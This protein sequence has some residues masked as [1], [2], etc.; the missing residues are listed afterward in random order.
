MKLLCRNLSCSRHNSCSKIIRRG[1]YFRSSDRQKVIRWTCKECKK[2]F[3]SA[4]RS[5][6]YWQKKRRINHPLAV[7]LA[8]NNSMRRCALILNVNRKTVARRLEFLGER[9]RVS[10]RKFLSRLSEVKH[11]E[12]DDLE[13]IEHTKLKPLSVAMAVESKSRKILSFSVS[14]MPAKGLIAAKSR[15]K[16]GPRPDRRPAGWHELFRSL[17]PIVSSEARFLS[18]QNPHY[19]MYVKK[20][21]PTAIHGTT[22]GQRGSL[23][24]QGELKKLHY[25]P[26]FSLN[27]SFAMLR[28]NICRLIRR[29]WCTTKKMSALEDHIAIY[30][31]FHNRVL[32]RGT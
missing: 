18:D 5:P 7:L 22:R 10:Q 13:T 6:A 24:G 32:L 3:S 19:P 9:A 2:T 20:Y 23:G 17:Q 12:F 1:V 21:F 28:A 26:L 31:D 8:S 16:Y 11:V 29:T 30:V 27:H 25:D 15:A 14:E 4:S